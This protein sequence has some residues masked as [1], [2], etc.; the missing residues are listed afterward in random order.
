MIF[1]IFSSGLHVA[2]GFLELFRPPGFLK[3][4]TVSKPHDFHDFCDFLSADARSTCCRLDSLKSRTASRPCDFHDFHD[5]CDFLSADARS[6]CC[7]LDSLKSRTASRPLS[8]PFWDDCSKHSASSNTDCDV[9]VW[10]KGV[11]ETVMFVYP[12]CPDSR[13]GLR[14]ESSETGQNF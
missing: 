10:K 4:R 2:A 8:H 13:W 11:C 7:R 3:S 5:F 12:S 9:K 6:T 1:V 14:R